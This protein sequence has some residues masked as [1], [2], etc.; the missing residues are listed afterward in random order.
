MSAMRALAATALAL[1]F[2]GC[3]SFQWHRVSIGGQGTRCLPVAFSLAAQERGLQGVKRVA[4]PMVFAYSPP[5]TPSFWMKDTPAPLTGVWVGAGRRVIGYW[6]GR[7]ESTVLHP[8]PAPVSAVIEYAAGARVPRLGAPV[9]LGR[10]C[11]PQPGG[12]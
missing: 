9:A 7:P 1:V 6:H 3:G 11:K 2:A 5:Q 10:P 12:L 8:A 4:R